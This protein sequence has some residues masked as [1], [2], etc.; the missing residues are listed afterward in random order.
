MRICIIGCGYVGAVTGTCFAE[1]GHEVTF[2][3]IDESKIRAINS[4][5]APVFEKGLQE[6]IKRNIERLSATNA[7]TNAIEVTDITFLCVGTPSNKDGSINLRY[8]RSASNDIGKALRKKKG[9]HIIVV[10]S[11]VLPRTTEEV[12]K[13]IIEKVSGKKAYKDFGLAVNP[14]FLREGNA[15]EDFLNPDHIIIGTNNN[16]TKK[17]VK[18]LY[19]SFDCPV[20]IDEIKTVEMIKYANNA[21]LATKISFTNEIGN[22]CKKLDIDSYNV[23]KGIGFDKRINPAFFRSGIGFGGSCLPKD[24]LALI[25]KSKEMGERPKILNAVIEVNKDQPLK[26]IEYLKKHIQSLNGKTIGILGLAFKPG[27]DDIRESRAIPLID[28]LIKERANIIVYDP[29][30]MN[31]FRMLFPQIIY[32]SS[33]KET[34]NS[35]AVLIVTEWEEF[36]HL[37]YK[38]KIVIDG[39]RVEKAKKDAAIYEGVCW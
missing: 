4:G 18:E 7:L 12:I 24:V 22:I 15:I 1:L 32:A 3:D 36:E 27:T 37:E 16:K 31:N 20:I 28:M 29:M 9:F 19:S 2:V 6:F 5:R 8:I 38:E 21:F 13:P 10:K 23:F 25:T 34:L 33:A 39:R 30:A 17:I 14:E 35:D 11:T 26:I